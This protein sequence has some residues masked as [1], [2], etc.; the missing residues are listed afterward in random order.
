MWSLARGPAR[1]AAGGGGDARGVAAGAA[2]R[3]AGGWCAGSW[4]QIHGA[5]HVQPGPVGDAL[6]FVGGDVEP[7][8]GAAE[9]VVV[10]G[11][12][13]E[14]LGLL[15][16]G[17]AERQAGAGDGGQHGGHGE[18]AHGDG[19]AATDARD[20]QFPAPRE[21]ADGAGIDD[22]VHAASSAGGNDMP[23]KAATA[24]AES[25]VISKHT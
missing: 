8:K 12:E 20:V 5:R 15:A 25:R 3:S 6:G 7:G 2:A 14:M 16:D 4:D 19:V 11:G 10:A 24:S 1:D 21:Q 9:L 17:V 13:L 23:A 18:V 22:G